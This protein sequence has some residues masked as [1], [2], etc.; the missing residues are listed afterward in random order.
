MDI[1]HEMSMNLEDV[2]LKVTAIGEPIMLACG[3]Y[4]AER[5]KA[6]GYTYLAVNPD[7]GRVELLSRRKTFINYNDTNALGA[8]ITKLKQSG[9]AAG[10]GPLAVDRKFGERISLNKC[11]EVLTAIFK[12]ILPKSGFEVRNSQAELGSEILDALNRRQVLLAEGETGTGKTWAYLIAAILIK[13]GRV[14]DYWNMGYYPDMQYADM[15]HMPI[16]AATSSIALQKALVED[17]IP[18]LSDILLEHKV[19]DSPITAALRKGRGHYVCER[20]LRAYLQSL[21]HLQNTQHPQWDQQLQDTPYPHKQDTQHLQNTLNEAASA[22][23]QILSRLLKQVTKNKNIDLSE[24]S[25]LSPYIKRKICVPSRCDYHCP[26]FSGCAYLNFRESAE[27]SE[28]D[29]QVCNH[30]YLLADTMNRAEDKPALIPNYQSIIIDEAHKFYQA[31]QTMYGM[32][33]PSTITAEIKDNIGRLA[34]RKESS[35]T[36]VRKLAKKLHDE[37]KRLFRELISSGG[38]SAFSELDKCADES[39]RLTV[40]INNKVANHLINMLDISD[41]LIEIMKLCPVTAGSGDYKKL[42]LGE[43]AALQDLTD[44][45]LDVEDFIFWLEPGGMKGAERTD[46]TGSS[47]DNSADIIT[48]NSTDSSVNISANTITSISSDYTKELKLC[49]MPKDLGQRL[50]KDL[51]GKGIPIVLTSGTLSAGGDFTHIRRQLCLDGLAY[52][53]L[54]ETTKPSPFNYANQTLLY[55]SEN[56]PFPNNKDYDY[57]FSLANEIEQLLY[58]SRGHAA[59]LFTSYRAMDMVW[60]HLSDRGLPFPLFR[61]DKG[62]TYAIEQ[63]KESGNGV[64]FASGSMWEGIDIPGDMLSML[65]IP[66]LPFAAPDPVND[67]ERT[68][69][70]DMFDFKQKV[71]IPEMLIKLKQGFGRLIRT[72]RD[73]GCV[74]I[75]DSRV[76]KYGS[77][78]G[79]VLDVLPT[80]RVT[81]SIG[82]AEQFFKLIKPAAYHE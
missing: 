60:E 62:G 15:A 70:G 56:L 69:Y 59:V 39:E 63:F 30:Q 47:T 67:Y 8:L 78:R 2:P 51:F 17:Y 41:E 9:I 50:Y 57:I 53:R 3:C 71:V 35:G 26:H 65:I 77:Y 55:I 82:V 13:R 75:L 33:Y 64:L 61:M 10:Y 48:S 23:Q 38:Q 52:Y 74:A 80:C 7:K 27:S 34:F 11:K 81:D 22:T 36:A 16:V 43:I 4:V 20:K 79:R 5:Q 58:A 68:L 18:M 32:E 45:L 1:M 6:D 37:N 40:D 19:I 21:Q 49:T 54:K 66:K 29:V 31:A 14:N 73:T 72:V 44:R 28:I 12:D 46:S 76:N 25:G 24:I 42:I